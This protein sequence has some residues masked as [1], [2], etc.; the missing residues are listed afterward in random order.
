MDNNNCSNIKKSIVISI[1]LFISII[2][3]ILYYQEKQLNTFISTT[4][5]FRLLKTN[6]TNIYI[7][8]KNDLRD[9]K[10]SLN[11]LLKIVDKRSDNEYFNNTMKEIID[12]YKISPHHIKYREFNNCFPLSDYNDIIEKLFDINYNNKNMVNICKRRFENNKVVYR[13]VKMTKDE[14]EKKYDED[15][16][17]EEN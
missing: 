9:N 10:K 6:L 16:V 1:I 13:W 17:C 5:H 14:A 3:I 8:L 7:D 15:Y 12:I 4:S 2:G 11:H